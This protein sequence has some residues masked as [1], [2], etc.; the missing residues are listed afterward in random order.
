[1]KVL[2][3]YDLFSERMK[4]KPVTNA[5]WEQVHKDFVEKTYCTK[6]NS[7]TFADIR[8]GNAVYVDSGGERTPYIVFDIKTL[9]LFLESYLSKKAFAD[10]PETIMIRYNTDN[11]KCCYRTVKSFKN[12]FPYREH[13]D[14]VKI[15]GIYHTNIDVDDMQSFEDLNKKWTAL[16]EKIEIQ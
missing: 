14:D 5:E 8:K 2:N 15:I 6:I 9:P 4:F 16:C 13:F 7:P 12:E 11:Q 3:T 1:M 10:N